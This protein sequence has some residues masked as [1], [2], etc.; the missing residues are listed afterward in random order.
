METLLHKKLPFKKIS[1]AFFVF[2]A[3]LFVWFF[4]STQESNGQ[5]S[6][7][8]NQE[9]LQKEE[10]IPQQEKS[11]KE[12]KASF[13]EQKEKIQEKIQQKEELDIQSYFLAKKENN[14]SICSE[15]LD[16]ALQEKCQNEVILH[17]ALQEKSLSTCETISDL[18]SQL[19]CNDTVL[20]DIAKEKRD[21]SFCDKISNTQFQMR[22]FEEKESYLSKTIF[23]KEDC[24]DLN[25]EKYRNICIRR[26]LTENDFRFSPLKCESLSDGDDKL[27][28]QKMTISSAFS[29]GEKVK[30]EMFSGEILE[31]CIQKEKTT[32]D[33]NFFTKA[34]EIKNYRYCEKIIEKEKKEI[35]TEEVLYISAWE[36][37][38]ISLCDLIKNT[39]VSER[40]KQEQGEKLNN[41]FYRRAKLE[42][43]KLL[44]LKI[45]E[46][47]LQKKCV[48][49]FEK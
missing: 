14:I 37:K 28:C 12:G 48:Q 21:F 26:F 17:I 23:K 1:A 6:S 8:K 34:I 38:D 49:F 30:C 44:C 22:C 3:T 32:N 41:F 15:I 5:I 36:K 29:E 39:E 31:F 16:E 7:K 13:I 43:D 35:C 24:K 47:E 2:I 18:K 4:L 20:F 40:C 25:I 46:S 9:V 42:E 11:L 45:F 27:L 10:K 33:E 19:Y